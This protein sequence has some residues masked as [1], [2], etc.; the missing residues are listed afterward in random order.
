MVN[1]WL[2][3]RKLQCAKHIPVHT[4]YLSIFSSN[5]GKYGPEKIQYGHFSRSDFLQKVTHAINGTLYL[6]GLSLTLAVIGRWFGL[7][8]AR[9]SWLT[10]AIM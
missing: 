6:K 4:P 3:G 9:S 8:Q 2:Y 1:R 5:V 7:K 10:I